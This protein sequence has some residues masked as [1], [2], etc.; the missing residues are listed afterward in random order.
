MWR[1]TRGR[2]SLAVLICALVT[3]VGETWTYTAIA[4]TIR[5]RDSYL[6][7]HLLFVVDSRSV[8]E[9]ENEPDSRCYLPVHETLIRDEVARSC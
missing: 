8:A 3:N 1:E 5:C 6:L 9:S 7:F 2:A 4:C